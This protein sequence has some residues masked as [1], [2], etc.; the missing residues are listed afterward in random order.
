[1]PVSTRLRGRATEAI[2]MAAGRE[3]P[4]PEARNRDWYG[5][6]PVLGAFPV[7]PAASLVAVLACVVY[8]LAAP[9]KTPRSQLRSLGLN[10][11][12]A[13]EHVRALRPT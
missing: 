12:A 1:M 11:S 7:A 10:T 13:V 5:S 6:R 2:W 3:V 4:F 9:N 8:G